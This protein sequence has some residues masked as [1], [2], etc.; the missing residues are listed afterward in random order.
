M[1]QVTVPV[2]VVDRSLRMMGDVIVTGG[3]SCH[4]ASAKAP[5]NDDTEG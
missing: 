2:V 5:S 1:R 3:C 4:D